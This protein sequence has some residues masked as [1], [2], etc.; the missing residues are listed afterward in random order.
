MLIEQQNCIKIVSN[1]DGKKGIKALKETVHLL[2]SA[3]RG[4]GIFQEWGWGFFQRI[5][6]SVWIESRMGYSISSHGNVTQYIL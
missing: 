1:Q 3:H 5:Y 2:L 6:W 4:V